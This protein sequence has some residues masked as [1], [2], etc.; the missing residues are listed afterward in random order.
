MIVVVYCVIEQTQISTWNECS[1][2]AIE[3]KHHDDVISSPASSLLNDALYRRATRNR[4]LLFTVRVQL[5]ICDII[6]VK[7][8]EMLLFSFSCTPYIDTLRNLWMYIVNRYIKILFLKILPH[9][10]QPSIDAVPSYVYSV[11]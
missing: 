2:V 8:K 9:L 3:P 11:L 1:S 5:D 10:E 4:F 6:R 7:Q